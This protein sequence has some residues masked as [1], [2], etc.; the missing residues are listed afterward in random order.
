MNIIQDDAEAV[1][2]A[3]LQQESAWIIWLHG[4]G[5]D[6]HDFLPIVEQLSPYRQH[7]RFIFPNAPERPI[8][9]NG[10]MAMPGWY[11]ILSLDISAK[12]DEMGLNQSREQVFSYIKAAKAKGIPA[13]RIFLAGFSQGGAVAL[14]A[15]L[16][17]T[18]SLGGILAL[19]TYLPLRYQFDAYVHAQSRQTPIFMGHGSY[20]EVISLAT[21]EQSRHFLQNQQYRLDWH[22]YPM[23]H[24]VCA[25]EIQHLDSW[26]QQRIG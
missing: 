20:D 3:P 6:G 2:L 17:Y 10:G 1:V 5:A 19:S 24:S 4:L 25:D 23:A 13:N 21:A 11:D 15:G 7:C 18:E 16:S 14:Y 26:L 8:T 9:I 12:Q 22:T